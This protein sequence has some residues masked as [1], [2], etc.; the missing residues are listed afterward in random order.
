MTA[1]QTTKYNTPAE[2]S[3]DIHQPESV[4]LDKLLLDCD[5]FQ[6]PEIASLQ[7]KWNSSGLL[8]YMQA[9]CDLAKS[10]NAEIDKDCIRSR[11]MALGFDEQAADEF[12]EY[13]I[14]RGLLSQGSKPYLITNKKVL[15]DQQNVARKR[16]EWRKEKRQQRETPRTIAG[17][18]PDNVRSPVECQN[19]ER[20]N[21]EDLK[22]EFLSEGGTGETLSFPPHIPPKVCDA[23][24]RWAAYMLKRHK[25]VF[26]QMA[27]E[28]TLMEYMTRLDDLVENI[29]YSIRSCKWVSIN[30]KPPDRDKPRAKNDNFQDAVD[31]YEKYKRE[32]R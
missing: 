24:N 32:G 12:I 22:N 27:V 18:S 5:F 23:L 8:L 2:N 19:T 17:Q 9:L 15:N 25:R 14:E 3:T 26:D 16:T 20:E 1:P 31:L 7:Y 28:S 10:R 11:S 4:E 6:K 30:Q 13:C 21:T 29:N